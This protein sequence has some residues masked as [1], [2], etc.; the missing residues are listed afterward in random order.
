MLAKVWCMME[1]K[2]ETTRLASY[3]DCIGFRGKTFSIMVN[4]KEK[5]I[6]PKWS[7]KEGIVKPDSKGFRVWIP[8]TDPPNCPRV[9]SMKSHRT[10]MAAQYARPPD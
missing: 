7:L 1:N 9:S 8:Q 6:K 3:A 5:N 10:T 2:L 4:Q